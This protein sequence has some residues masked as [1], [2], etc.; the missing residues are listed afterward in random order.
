MKEFSQ[1]HGS[2]LVA[3]IPFSTVSNSVSAYAKISEFEPTIVIQDFDLGPTSHSGLQ[4]MKTI[5]SQE[6]SAKICV[7]SK[8]FFMGDQ[9]EAMSNFVQYYFYCKGKWVVSRIIFQKIIHRNSH[10]QRRNG[11]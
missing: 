4:I 2:E 7:H 10:S 6:F 5:R 3:A 9:N 8:K 11:P 1:K